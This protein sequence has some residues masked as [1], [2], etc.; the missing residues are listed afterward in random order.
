M[1]AAAKANP[2]AG[3][4]GLALFRSRIHSRR[5]FKCGLNP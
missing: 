2:I 1:I 4:Y 3:K 5:R